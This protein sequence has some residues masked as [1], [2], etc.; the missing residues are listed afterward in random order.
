VAS[1][2]GVIFDY[3]GVLLNMRWDVSRQ[4]EDAHGL[5]R[6]TVIES[7]YRTPTWRGIERGRGDRQAWLQEAHALLEEKVG[8]ALPRLHETW[9][10]AQ[11]PIDANV[12]LAGALRPAYRTAILSNADA[13]LRERL[14]ETGLHD[15]FDTIVSSAEEG[16]AK[17]EAAIYRLAAARLDLA[18]DA[19]VFIDD[20]EANVEAAV[21]VGMQGILFRIDRSDDLRAML[22]ELGVAVPGSPRPEGGD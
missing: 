3:G 18:P 15:L 6:G 16:L 4:L 1:L 9:R 8:R 7:L 14:R 17:P 13:S 19:C 22:A 11:H 20:Y 2:A 21:S 10:E 5:P 12:A